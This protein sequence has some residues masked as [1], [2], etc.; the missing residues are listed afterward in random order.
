MESQPIVGLCKDEKGYYAGIMLTK[1]LPCGGCGKACLFAVN[2]Y[3][4]TRCV[5]CDAKFKKTLK[6]AD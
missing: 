2:R 3:G 5:E 6:D 4:S 1:P